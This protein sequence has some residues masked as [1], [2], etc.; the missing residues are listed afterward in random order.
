M[1]DPGN[2]LRFLEHWKVSR[3]HRW[4]IAGADE[5]EIEKGGDN[6]IIEESEM[7]ITFVDISKPSISAEKRN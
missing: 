2:Y 1:K 4:I 7:I 3:L 5:V 6:G